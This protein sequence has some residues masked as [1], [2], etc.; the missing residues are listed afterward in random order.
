M[1]GIGH[2]YINQLPPELLAAVFLLTEYHSRDLTS[3]HESDFQSPLYHVCGRWRELFLGDPRFWSSLHGRFQGWFDEK[4]ITQRLLLC[5]ERSASSPLHFKLDNSAVDLSPLNDVIRSQHRWHR[6][7]LDIIG[8]AACSW[9]EE[10][11][12]SELAS[13][14]ATGISCFQKVKH[15]DLQLKDIYRSTDQ[16]HLP[17]ADLFPNLSHLDFCASMMPD[18]WE[19]QP[20]FEKLLPRQLRHLKMSENFKNSVPTLHSILSLLRHVE[21][22][23]VEICTSRPSHPPR[24]PSMG[25]HPHLRRLKSF[26]ADHLDVEIDSLNCP[27]LE[28]LDIAYAPFYSR[29]STISFKSIQAWARRSQWSLQELILTVSKRVHEIDD[30]LFELLEA[31]STLR[32]LR[33]D[34]CSCSGRFLERLR[35]SNDPVLPHLKDLWIRV[36]VT[37]KDERGRFITAFNTFAQDP[38]LRSGGPGIRVPQGEDAIILWT[39]FYRTLRARVQGRSTDVVTAK[40]R[41]PNAQ[42]NSP[43]GGR[44]FQVHPYPSISSIAAAQLK[45]QPFRIRRRESDAKHDIVGREIRCRD[46]GTN[47]QAPGTMVSKRL[48]LQKLA[49]SLPLGPRC[50]N[51]SAYQ[52]AAYWK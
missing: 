49:G 7:S 31:L 38:R 13:L 41:P 19:A 47:A 15:L 24:L 44:R 11:L 34:T 22:L 21:D 46:P 30:G 27:L 18:V 36:N 9:L 1:E 2:D 28:R 37:G 12:G 6:L 16:I 42:G 45:L 43:P 25:V 4:T 26:D 29:R 39:G 14:T 40:L 48:L 35:M 10:L 20:F 32:S 50:K 51:Y 17:I 52:N 8:A 33:L 5:F 23:D 3:F